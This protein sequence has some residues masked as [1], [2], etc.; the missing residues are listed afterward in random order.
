MRARFVLTLLAVAATLLVTACG[1]DA[2][3]SGAASQQVEG[4]TFVV[5]AADIFEVDSV[6]RAGW[7]KS[8]QLSAGLL[9]G[10][11]EVWY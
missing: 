10:A 11:V 7:K 3:P 1:S 8:K 5:R 4:G 2:E 9:P 6:T